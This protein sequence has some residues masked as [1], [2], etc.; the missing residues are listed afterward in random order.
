MS[1]PPDGLE[2]GTQ[3]AE[4]GY[5]GYVA[6]DEANVDDGGAR[7]GGAQQKKWTAR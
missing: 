2:A 5:E 7:D 1:P 3:V 4:R 6:K